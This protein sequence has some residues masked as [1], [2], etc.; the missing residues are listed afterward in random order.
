LKIEPKGHLNNWPKDPQGNYMAR[1]LFPEPVKKTDW[2]LLFQ[3]LSS[4]RQ[5]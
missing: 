2:I 3:R 5:P 4:E 1:L